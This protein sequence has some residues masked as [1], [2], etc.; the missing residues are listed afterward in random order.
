MEDHKLDQL[1]ED[2]RTSYRVPPAP[3]VEAIWQAV[4]AEAFA[5]RIQTGNTHRTLDWRFAG[6]LAAASLVIGI[7]GG[8][9]STSIAPTATMAA[10]TESQVSN[11]ASPYARTTEEVLGRSAVLL[12]ALRSP[13]SRSVNT[14]QVSDQAQRLLGNVRLLLDSPAAADPQMQTLLL[15][16]ELT[17]AQ[18]ARMQP[19][20][21]ETDLTLINDAVAHREIVPRIRSAVVEMSAGSY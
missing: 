16:L 12:A 20:R 7:F 5:P 3:A 17:L 21:G 18:V 19:A 2:V 13:D 8:R 1:L 4:E 11:V 15:D 10:A 6:M 14:L 9:W